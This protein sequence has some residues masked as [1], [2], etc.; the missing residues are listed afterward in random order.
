[1]P[2]EREKTWEDKNDEGRDGERD[3]FSRGRIGGSLKGTA[4]EIE[5]AVSA[6][7]RSPELRTES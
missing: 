7:T 2:S 6:I 5:A 4:R 3:Q 1:M